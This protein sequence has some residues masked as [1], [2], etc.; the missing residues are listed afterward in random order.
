MTRALE[1]RYGFGHHHFVTFSC[2]RRQPFLADPKA[3]NT[4]ES[5]LEATRRKYGFTID[6]YV[7]MP[8][9]VHLLVSE[10]KLKNLSVVM[11]ALKIS[12]SRRSRQRP[13]WQHRFYDF[14]VFTD[15]KRLEKRRYMHRNPFARGLVEHPRDWAWSSYRH[16]AD[17]SDGTVEV[18]SN[19]AFAR[20]MALTGFALPRAIIL[21]THIS[22]TRC[23]APISEAR[24]DD[25]I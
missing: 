20:R 5:C 25:Q 2:Y 9:H 7:V 6:S 11:Q 21:Q 17:G 14:N 3:R 23:G 10:P 18:E 19:W 8:E 4:L 12:V 1:R 16:W 24:N 22:N 15:R 13:F